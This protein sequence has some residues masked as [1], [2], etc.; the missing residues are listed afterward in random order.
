M[1]PARPGESAG[2]GEPA[3]VARTLQVRLC[4]LTGAGFVPACVMLAHHPRCWEGP[5][6]TLSSASIPS[7]KGSQPWV[8]RGHDVTTEGH[9]ATAEVLR[10][11]GV[12]LHPL[13][14]WRG[15]GRARASGLPCGRRGERPAHVCASLGGSGGRA[16]AAAGGASLSGG[17]RGVR[18]EATAGSRQDCERSGG[19]A[20]PGLGGCWSQGRPGRAGRRRVRDCRGRRAPPPSATVPPQRPNLLPEDPPSVLTDGTHLQE[21]VEGAAGRG[22]QRGHHLRGGRQTSV[23]PTSWSPSHLEACDPTP[24][25]TLECGAW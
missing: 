21:P 19:R 3:G 13:G 24:A 25:Q 18:S 10:A 6:A 9:G 8:S 17:G 11:Q 23:S 15:A 12:G 5:G 4:P 2:R 20:G 7:L 1:R 16:G 14:A 22:A